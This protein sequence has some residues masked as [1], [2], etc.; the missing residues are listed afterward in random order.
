MSAVE[1]RSSHPAL[2]SSFFNLS[3]ARRAGGVGLVA[4]GVLI[5]SS[6]SLSAQAASTPTTA[7]KPAPPD[8][9]SS[10]DAPD[11]PG[12]LATDISPELKPKAIQAV[13]EKVASW[14]VKAA[15]PTFNRLWTYAALYD[16]LIAAS[17]TTGDPKFRD[18][19]LKFSEQEKWMLIDN[20]FPHADDQALGKAYMELYLGD[21]KNARKPERMTN[22]KEII[23]RLVV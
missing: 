15:E 21:P 16:G 13:V 22:T 12:P 19:V 11:D 5:G 17:K 18:A 1:L 23:D 14:Q 10:G 6:T 20:R 3:F 2:N 9:K 8:S 7:N 4:L